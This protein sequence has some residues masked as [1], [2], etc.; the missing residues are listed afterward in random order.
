MSRAIVAGV[1]LAAVGLL[2]AGKAMSMAKKCLFSEVQGVV[3]SNNQPV[4][5]AVVERE[6]RWTWKGETGKD[7][8]TTG[9]KGEF[10]FPAIYRS[11][12]GSFLPHEPM[13][14]QTILIRHAGQ[15]YKAWMLDKGNYEENGE[16]NGKPIVLVCRLETEPKR[17]GEVFGICDLQ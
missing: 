8:A 13:V 9:P 4:S 10:K 17:T 2:T 15:T 12:L 14:R 5:G 6:Y 7:Q 11:S 16:L 3:L 1:I